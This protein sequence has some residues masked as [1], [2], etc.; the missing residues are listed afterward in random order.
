MNKMMGDQKALRRSRQEADG[1]VWPSHLLRARRFIGGHIEIYGCPCQGFGPLH[2]SS[3]DRCPVQYV[4]LVL[5][6]HVGVTMKAQMTSIRTANFHAMRPTVRRET[7]SHLLG[8]Y[9][10]HSPCLRDMYDGA[11]SMGRSDPVLPVCGVGMHAVSPTE[12]FQEDVPLSRQLVQRYRYFRELHVSLSMKPALSMMASSTTGALSGNNFSR[13][14][15]KGTVISHAILVN[16]RQPGSCAMYV[17]YTDL[18][19]CGPWQEGNEARP[20]V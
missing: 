17:Q 8:T 10:S 4:R 20:K 16:T 6:R 1:G 18:G 7:D 2:R 12:S 11:I 3:L 9:A 15:S 19:I 14:L 13:P 5:P